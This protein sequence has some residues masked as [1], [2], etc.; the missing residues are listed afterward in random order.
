MNTS[1]LGIEF[2]K[3]WEGTKRNAKTR[4]HEPYKCSAG[5]LTIG[6][7][8][9]IKPDENFGEGIDEE[10]ATSLLRQDLGIAE[11]AV[12][13]LISK[14]LSQNQFDALV[15]LI[16]NI[17]SGNFAKSTIRKYI[18]EA[19]FASKEYPSPEL[20]WKAWNMAGGRVVQGLANRRDAEWDMYSDYACIII[21]T[22]L[23][24]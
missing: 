2:I 3:K 17:G 8:H 24:S 21:P 10:L 1:N 19:G 5:L 13:R 15:S 7:G 16:F 12:G 4:L 14:P 6:Y 11:R 18:N 20:A 9:L 23:Q 22:P